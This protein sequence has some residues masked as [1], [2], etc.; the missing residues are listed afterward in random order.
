MKARNLATN[1]Q[2]LRLVGIRTFF[3]WVYANKPLKNPMKDIAIPKEEVKDPLLISP[4]ELVQFVITAATPMRKTDWSAFVARRNAAM[5]CLLADT[6]IRESELCNLT[7][8]SVIEEKNHFKLIVRGKTGERIVPFS[9]LTEQ[10]FVAEYWLGYWQYRK[11]IMRAKPKDNLFVPI[12]KFTKEITPNGKLIPQTVQDTVRF[13]IARSPVKKHIYPHILRHYF[14]TYSYAN[15]TSLEILRQRMGHASIET[16]MRY[17][18][19]ADLY[20][21]PHLDKGPTAGLFAPAESQ[22]F[23][24]IQKAMLS[25]E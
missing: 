1:T 6:G 14:G 16:T 15:G 3:E 18:H 20:G 7:M 5:I 8:S 23:V 13:V 22:G 17:V 19:L 10:S 21:D 12:D 11:L 25:K 2:R 4:S 9:K 24:R